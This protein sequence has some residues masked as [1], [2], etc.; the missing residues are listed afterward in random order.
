MC[1]NVFGFFPEE[2]YS[3]EIGSVSEPGRRYRCAASAAWVSPFQLHL[4]VQIIDKYF[5]TMNALF[6]FADGPDGE[7]R[8]AVQMNKTAEDFLDGYAGFAASA[9]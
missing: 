6:G 5:G 9:Y 4:K 2:G 3:D 8:A 7:P 1:G